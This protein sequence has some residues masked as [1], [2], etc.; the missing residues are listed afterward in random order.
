M[1]LTKD[2]YYTPEADWEYMSC[3]QYQSFCEC[4]AK[5]MA[6][7]QGR[8]AEETREAFLVG[9]YFHTAM[10]SPEA[11]EEFCRTHYD[12]I[13]KYRILKSGEV[14]ENGKY[15]A[16]EQADKMLSVCRNDKLISSLIGMPGEN[17]VIMTGELFGVPWRIRMDK[18]CPDRNIIIDW[19]TVANINELKYNP[20]TREKET[21][22]EAYG[23]MM[24]AAIYSEIEKQ[25]KKTDKNAN[26]IIVA[27]SKQDYPDKEVLLLNHEQRYQWEL[28]CVKE[29]IGRI[30]ALKE[31]KYIRPIRCGVC[32][33]C[34]A[35]KEL[36]RIIP[37]YDLRP[38]SGKE[39]EE[40]DRFALN[41]EDTQA[42]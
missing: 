40:D 3:S 2:N 30:K 29:K 4:E 23:Y 19:K 41:L 8:W 5:A 31:Q 26:F 6:K 32:D 27:V 16:F 21:F 42:S 25:H 33:Y 36:K 28:S 18:Y 39:K 34:R 9:N 1:E 14:K 37:Y 12:D 22:V 20:M 35:T 11:H 38:D 24:R 15:A 13:F 7:L 17:E 10:E